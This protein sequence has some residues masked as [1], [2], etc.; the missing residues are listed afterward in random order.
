MLWGTPTDPDGAEFTPHDLPP[1]FA[2]PDSAQTLAVLMGAPP[3]PGETD[4]SVPTGAEAREGVGES[5]GAP[6][7]SPARREVVRRYFGS[8]GDRV[9]PLNETEQ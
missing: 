9:P 8:A 7:L 4:G 2:D 3:A 1:G 5:A 6:R